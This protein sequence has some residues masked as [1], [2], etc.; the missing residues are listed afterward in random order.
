MRILKIITV[1]AVVALPLA[2]GLWNTL[3]NAAQLFG[4]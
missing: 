4:G 1:W 3:E 2:Y